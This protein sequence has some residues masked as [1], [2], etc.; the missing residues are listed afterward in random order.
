MVRVVIL[1]ILLLVIAAGLMVLFKPKPPLQQISMARKS[2]IE[3]RRFKADDYFPEYY[4]EAEILY[5]SMMQEWKNQNN[6][7]FPGRDY[8]LVSYYSELTIARANEAKDHSETNISNLRTLLPRQLD[9]L[10][11]SIQRFD[12]MLRF[13]PLSKN[14]AEKYTKGRLLLLES[15][16]AFE[17]REYK[18]SYDKYIIAHELCTDVF[19]NIRQLLQAYFVNYDQWVKLTE[20]TIG[21]TKK[22]RSS[23]LVVDKFAK[24]CMLYQ[25]GQLK[26]TC[27]IELGPNWIGEKRH[28]GDNATPEG[29]YF[30]IKK[31]SSKE[32]RYYK[33]LLLNYPNEAD[34]KRFNEGLKNGTLPESSE[35]GGFIEIHGEGGRGFH[36]TNG[37]IALKNKDMDRIY[38]IATAGTPVVIVG[39]L[40]TLSEIY[41]MHYDG[42]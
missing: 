34:I 35:I 29:K 39:S 14:L 25:N 37:C 41:S 2:L 19:E 33:A 31:L 12:S 20:E 21:R 40:K 30:I 24:S 9:S 36:W 1:T 26:Y 13:I 22:M 3:A 15:K 32:T 18:S 11:N 17:N 8:S 42:L 23:A 10:H 28:Q 16:S 38:Y 4:Y 5:D 27:E 6:R 7:F